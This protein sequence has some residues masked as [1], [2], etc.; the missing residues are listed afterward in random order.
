MMNLTFL[1][2]CSFVSTLIY[3]FNIFL[4]PLQCALQ[5]LTVAIKKITTCA[6][7][8]DKADLDHY[9]CQT[10]LQLNNICYGLEDITYKIMH[11]SCNLFFNSLPCD[12][13]NYISDN[14]VNR[15]IAK[16]VIDKFY[17]LFINALKSSAST[18][19]PSQQGMAAHQKHWWCEELQIL[20]DR[21]IQSYRAWCTIGNPKNGDMFEIY[22]SDKYSFKLRTRQVKDE[23]ELLISK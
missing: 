19:M 4:T 23:A 5:I 17:P 18:T 2:I 7:R 12:C 10:K 3:P 16:F 9:Y 6:P 21:S 1:I 15:R 11:N 20:K 13:G 8:C 22:K 14:V